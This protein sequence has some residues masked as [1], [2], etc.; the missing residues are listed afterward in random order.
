[1]AT[2]YNTLN[3]CYLSDDLKKKAIKQNPMAAK[4][5]KE[6]NDH[7]LILEAIKQ[8]PKIIKHFTNHCYY[9]KKYRKIAINTHWFNKH[10]GIFSYLIKPIYYKIVE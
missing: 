10:L 2:I 6:K 3:S 1:M 5:L 9:N 8:E 7:K 4:Y